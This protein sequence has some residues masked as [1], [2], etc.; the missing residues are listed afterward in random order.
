MLLHIIFLILKIIGSI[1]LVVLGLLV[2]LVL[3]AFFTPLRYIAEG[4]C[5]GDLSSLDVHARFYILFHLAGADIRYKEE[6]FSWNFR[7]AWRHFSSEQP[8]ETA[9]SDTKQKKNP[10]KVTIIKQENSPE[11]ETIIKQE[12]EKYKR[13]SSD[14]KDEDGR[15]GYSRKSEHSGNTEIPKDEDTLDDKVEAFLEKIKCTFQNTCAKIELLVKK[16]DKVLDFLTD[17]IHRNAFADALAELK[18]VIRRLKPKRLKADICFGF[19]DPSVT[20]N[21]LA[22]YCLAYPFS[23][24]HVNVTPDFQRKILKGNFFIKGHVRA[25]IFAALGLNL[26]RSKNVRRTFHHIRNFKLSESL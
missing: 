26:I 22:L 14:K 5:E 3:F 10:E 4:S 16:K 11:K 2:L 13:L 9:N 6:K 25:G 23:G 18:K 21:I 15:P 1:F 20:G 19:E 7:I 24:E 17:E 8:E 12:A